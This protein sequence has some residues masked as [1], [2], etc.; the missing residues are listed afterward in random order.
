M[1]IRHH[2]FFKKTSTTNV[3]ICNYQRYGDCHDSNNNA[4]CDFDD[5]DC[6][7]NPVITQFCNECWCYAD[8]TSYVSGK[9]QLPQ[10][11]LVSN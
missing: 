9:I 2:N 1:I 10:N 3:I 6:C 11:Y 4:D 7:L 5:G 8:N